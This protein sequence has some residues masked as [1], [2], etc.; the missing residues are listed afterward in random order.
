MST[1]FY[2]QGHCGDDDPRYH[3]GLRSAAGL[4][5]WDC[6]VT[7]CVGGISNVHSHGSRW[8]DKCPKCGQAPAKETLLESASGRELG[9]NSS[10][11]RKKSG[12][13]SCSSFRWARRLGEITKIVDEY[14]NEYSRDEFLQILEEC[15]IRFVDSCGERFS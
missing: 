10:T 13:R 1:N 12:V 7:L 5:C 8:Y 14:E 15:P 6:G 9:F 3:I 2:I 11:P 4:Y